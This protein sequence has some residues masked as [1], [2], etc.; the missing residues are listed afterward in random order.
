MFK[1]F[2]PVMIVSLVCGVAAAV[3][4][5]QRAPDPVS[6]EIALS[7]DM[8]EAGRRFLS[9]LTPAQRGRAVFAVTA[10]ERTR[11]HYVPRPRPGLALKE[12]SD[13]QRALAYGLLA[14][15]L[16]RRGFVKTTGIMALEDVLRQR[17][18][19]ALRDAGAY[20]ISV[21]G[22][23][24]TSTTWGFR[25]EGHLLSLNLT[26]VDGVR[27]IESPAFLG[28]SPS[29]VGSGFLAETRVL[30]REEDLGFRL[31]GSLDDE[32]RKT[33]V[34]RAHRARRHPH[35][36]GREAHRAAGAR[37]RPHDRGAAPGARRAAR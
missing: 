20:F 30:G 14:A 19:E 15:A 22:E 27:P 33:A 5:A 16:S 35:R 29:Q 1:R 36:T 25:V 24:S 4:L 9:A 28:A 23:P 6:A 13:A 26:L 8:A 2:P 34:F 12:L 32:Q 18:H 7:A 31:L 11:W 37:G 21:F 3:A 17:E 10:D